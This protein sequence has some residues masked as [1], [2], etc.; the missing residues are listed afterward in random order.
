MQFRELDVVRVARLLTFERPFD[1][2][3]SVARRRASA[4]FGAIV[5]VLGEGAFIVECVNES[6]LTA[7]IADF[8]A[9]EIEPVRVRA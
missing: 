3:E 7:W 9:A 2:A 5:D 4:I 1:G 6:G 8:V